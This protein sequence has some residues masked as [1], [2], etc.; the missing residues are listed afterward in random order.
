MLG[1]CPK[2]DGGLTMTNKPYRLPDGG[3]RIDR[4][5][6]IAITFDRKSIPAFEGDTVAS[7]VL[8][9]G[10]KI[11]GRSFKYHRAR[12]VVGLGSE[13][14]NALIGVGVGARHEP[15]LR[16]TQIE[17]FDGLTA[18][19]QNRWPSLNFDIGALNNK[20]SRF[21]PGG[22]YYKTFMWPQSFWKHIYEPII[23]RAAGL[24]KAATERDPDTYE[25]M[26]AHVDV[27]VVG[28]GI[29][30]LT[31]AEFAA[32]AGARVLLADENPVLGGIADLT[33]AAL[34]AC[35]LPTTLQRLL[36]A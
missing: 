31:A 23:R 5:K 10:Q 22:F 2:G 24:G 18:V 12:G 4:S 28:G 13:E 32:N 3:S 1:K 25:H 20:V 30:G 11:F 33:A 26:H 27:L 34:M 9:S 8:A 29:A 16:A 15:N 21:I 17:L 14:M 35:V 19:S 36:S 6:R 7:A